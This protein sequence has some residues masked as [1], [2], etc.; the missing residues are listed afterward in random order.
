[1]QVAG[2]E[3]GGTAGNRSLEDDGI[4]GWK[5]IG[6]RGGKVRSDRSDPAQQ[7]LPGEGG[8]RDIWRQDY[9]RLPR[10]RRRW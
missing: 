8:S 5:A 3:M 2:E 6:K 4:L 1:M 10:G 9:V 7:G